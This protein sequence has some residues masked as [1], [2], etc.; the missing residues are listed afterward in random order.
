MSKLVTFKVDRNSV[1]IPLK[2]VEAAGK[3]DGCRLSMPDGTVLK[4][5]VSVKA[6]TKK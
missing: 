6:K 3:A 5:T 1:K 4:V 2:V